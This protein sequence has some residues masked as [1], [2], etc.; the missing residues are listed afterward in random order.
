MKQQ[1]QL[2]LTILPEL[3][4]VGWRTFSAHKAYLYI[5]LFTLIAYKH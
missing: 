1:V 5:Y 3:K 4:L 2:I